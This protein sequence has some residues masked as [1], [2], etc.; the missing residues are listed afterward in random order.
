VRVVRIQWPVGQGCFATG[1]IESDGGT[2]H[3]VYDCG[4]R[5]V[6]NLEP[7]V[8]VY[9]R[10][11]PHVDAL[12]VSHLDGDHVDGLD[13]LLARLDVTTVYLPYLSFGQRLLEVAEAEA[14]DLRLTASFVQAQ[15]DPASWFGSRGVER[16]VFVRNG[17]EP[18]DFAAGEPIRP[19]PEFRGEGRGP[20]LIEK[21]R[22][23]RLEQG[24]QGRAD[25]LEMQVD[26]H[27]AV[28]AG[29]RIIDW[30]LK[31]Y[32]P[33]VSDDRVR[34]F[35]G[36]V[37]AAL[38]LAPGAAID[39]DGLKLLLK[40]PEG[41]AKLRGCYDAILTD[42]AGKKHNA[43]SMSLYSGPESDN[44]SWEIS[45]RHEQSEIS[46]AVTA[47]AGW[48]GT[49]D[50]KLKATKRRKNWRSYY[51]RE[52]GVTRTLLLPHHGSKANFHDELLAAPLRICI[53][54]ADERDAGYE[55]PS[56]EVVDAIDHADLFLAH[57][58]KR[59]TS[60]YRETIR[61]V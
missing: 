10:H 39:Q 5:S 40:T 32:V 50:A 54:A 51:R 25:V 56:Q 27:I 36:K 1:A 43:V 60:R 3:Y 48:I 52:L 18:D 6:S 33:R 23:G 49:G 8:A 13:T 22:V 59:S 7:I 28:A 38:G 20:A 29:G 16:I 4:A 30:I 34:Q 15:F 21:S 57:V 35:E 31:P 37:R 14:Q 47:N 11:V 58:T 41:R 12:F 55:H 17:G 42:G 26:A 9:A 19:D 53:A 46:F 45:S 2:V 44:G 24:D 61:K